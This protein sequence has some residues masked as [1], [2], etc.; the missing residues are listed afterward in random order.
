[1][2][3]GVLVVAFVALVRA[4]SWIRSVTEPQ[5]SPV[6]SIGQNKKPFAKPVGTRFE[7]DGKIQYF[8]GVNA[9][10]LGHLSNDSDIETAMQQIADIGYKIIRVWGFGD[11]EQY[12]R[13][14][15]S[16]PYRVW[17]QLH[18]STG[19]ESSNSTPA[20]VNYGPDGLQR[21]DYVVHT[22]ER[23]QLKLVLPFVNYWPDLGGMDLYTRVYGWTPGFYTAGGPSRKAYEAWIKIVVER[24]KHS[25]A[26]FSWQLA[27]EPRCQSCETT[28][29]TEWVREISKYIKKL[30]PYHMVTD[31]SEGWFGGGNGYVDDKGEKSFAYDNWGGADFVENLKVETIDYGCFHLYPNLWNVPYEW[32]NNWI[33]Q[34]ADAALK[35]NKPVI[36]EEYGSP[37][38]DN[39]TTVIGP[40]QETVLNSHIAADQIWQF[41]PTNLTVDRLAFGDIYSVYIDKHDFEAIGKKHAKAMLDKAVI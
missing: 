9:W 25:E 17:Y 24:Y 35:L 7:V 36:L 41:G 37:D 32:G 4:E 19:G 6:V 5:I 29:L 10:W 20:Y 26:I 13:P 18:N 11:V 31:G 14:A 34:H 16:D 22:A 12:P 15:L 1:M 40:W 8:A 28:V 23:L 30:D 2:W 38:V 39:H 33:R 21:L 27:N 3:A